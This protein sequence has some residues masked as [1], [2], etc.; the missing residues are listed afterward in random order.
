VAQHFQRTA[1]L[2]QDMTQS[3]RSV[4]E[5]LAGGSQQLCSEPLQTPQLDLPERGR[6]PEA[7][8]PPTPAP[9]PPPHRQADT[10]DDYLGDAPYVPNLVFSEDADTPATNTD[11]PSA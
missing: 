2:V 11:K 1:E 10:G 4:Y 8:K 3:Y 5:H 9:A 6:L 7:E